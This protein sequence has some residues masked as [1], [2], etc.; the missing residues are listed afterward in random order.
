MII[1][2]SK[3]DREM[4]KVLKEYGIDN[5]YCSNSLIVRVIFAPFILPKGMTSPSDDNSGGKC[6]LEILSSSEFSNV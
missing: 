3:A 2:S 6:R 1:T 5:V 4:Q